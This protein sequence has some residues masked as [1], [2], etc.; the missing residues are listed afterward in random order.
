MTRLEEVEH[1]LPL[2]ALDAPVV[3]RTPTHAIND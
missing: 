2:A 3:T 1:D